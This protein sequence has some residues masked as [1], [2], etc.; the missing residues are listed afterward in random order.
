MIHSF[1]AFVAVVAFVVCG[2]SLR[3]QFAFAVVVCDRSFVR[4]LRCVRNLRSF[5]EFTALRAFIG[6]LTS[7]FVSWSVCVVG[8]CFERQNLLRRDAPLPFL[9]R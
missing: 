6:S 7:L 9:A 5:V 1:V 2:R 3:S 4:S 8:A